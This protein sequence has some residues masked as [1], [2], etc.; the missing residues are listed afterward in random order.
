MNKKQLTLF[1]AMLIAYALA[2]FISYAFLLDSM[3]SYSN[4]PTPELVAPPV[5]LGLINAGVILVLYGLIGLAGYW[6][7]RRLNLPGIFS[8]DGNWRRWVMI[9]LIIGVAGGII[10]AASDKIFAPIN[11][12]GSLPHPAFPF[13]ILASLSA[14]IGEEI[15]FRGFV[16]GLWAYLLNLILKRWN[17]TNLALWIANIIAALAFSAGHLPGLMYLMGFSTMGDLPPVL[18]VEIILLNS[19]VGL[20]A[21]ERYMKDGLIAAAGVHFCTDIVWHVIW[22]LVSGG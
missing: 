8:E 13:S 6:F 22:P 20:V 4:A 16:F 19:I 14:G 21:G 5:V 2:A 10:L 15:A 18:V 11:G 7:A 1:T 12:L 3:L 9:P 17:R